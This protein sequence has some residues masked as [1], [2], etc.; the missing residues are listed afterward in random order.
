MCMCMCVHVGWWFWES[1]DVPP[2]SQ[3]CPALNEV[4]VA[5][6]LA[7]MLQPRMKSHENCRDAGLALT[8]W[9]SCTNGSSCIP[10]EKFLGKMQSRFESEHVPK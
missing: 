1:F 8:H 6:V 3:L 10:L 4:M 9:S 5:E 2:P 7:T